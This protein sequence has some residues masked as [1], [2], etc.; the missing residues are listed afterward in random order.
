MLQ[1][2]PPLCDP[3]D[4]S[5]PGSAVPGILQARVLEWGASPLL[6]QG[7]KVKSER[8]VAQ[9]CPALRP[10]GLQPTRPCRPWNF[11]GKSTGVGCHC[12]LPY[13]F[14]SL[15][16]SLTSSHLWDANA[17]PPLAGPRGEK[18]LT[19]GG[20]GKEQGT[21]KLPP[22][23]ILQR[24]TRGQQEMGDCSPE[25][26]ATSSEQ[27]RPSIVKTNSMLPKTNK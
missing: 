2:C 12:L 6:L 16:K 8:E 20:P 4:G 14:T 23:R 21:N 10:H 24:S 22:T 9:L 11:P 15:P 26:L 25:V 5:P 18:T 19:T 17:H 3:I 13:L 1:S 7:M 27:Q